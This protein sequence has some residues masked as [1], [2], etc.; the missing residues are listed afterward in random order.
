MQTKA[1]SNKKINADIPI[2]QTKA[3]SK[4][5]VSF[6]LNLFLLSKS[7]FEPR[8]F[9]VDC[10]R[11]SNNLISTAVLLFDVKDKGINSLH[12]FACLFFI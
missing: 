11:G 7:P 8:F 6:K 3:S 10:G 9:F 1:S 5:V 4:T 12:C 2:M